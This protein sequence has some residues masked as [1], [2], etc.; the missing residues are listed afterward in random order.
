VRT[1]FALEPGL[2]TQA[3]E[4]SHDGRWPDLS[5]AGSARLRAFYT[6]A[7]TAATAIEESSLLE[8][9]RVDRKIL[10][11]QIDYAL[12]TLDELRPLERNPLTYVGLIGDALDPLLT[13]DFAPIEVRMAS[14][15]SRLEG[16]PAVVAAAR[17]RLTR[18]PRVFTETA[19]A[20]TRGLIEL[21]SHGLDDSLAKVPDQRPALA[22]ASAKATAAL[23]ELLGFFERELLPRSDGDFRLG[24]T[25]FERKLRYELGDSLDIDALATGA[26]AL[27]DSTR[28]D[29]VA[30]SIELWPSLMGKRPLPKLDSAAGK[31]AMVKSVLDAVAADRPSNATILAEATKMLAEA[32]AFVQKHDLVRVPDEPCAVIE[33]PEYRRGV[34]VAY[35][36][37]SGPFE[38]RP[39]TY[40]AISPT[41]KDWSR[42]RVDSF[43]KEYNRSMLMELTIH[44]AMP[45]HFLQAMHNNRFPSKLRALYS[46]GAFVEGWAVY[47]EWVMARY[48]M[49]GPKV[50]LQRQKMVLR[51]CANAILDH[52]IHAGTMDEKQALAL[53]QGDAFQEEGEAVGKWKR[54]RLS[55]AQ[56]STYY[57]GF[58]EFMK[59]RAATETRAGFTERGFHDR[60]LSYGAPPMK[61][62]SELMRR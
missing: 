26:R 28:E 31:R 18:P 52:E 2:A 35:C 3:G 45:G 27:L 10:L 1:L 13:R 61:L 34:A 21:T 4:H 50:R 6:E 46:S 25:L 8:T 12:F 19:I 16:I 39:E 37:S 43:Y 59:I 9:H 20:Q 57:Y 32:T 54:A 47:G 58:S 44:E 40:Y 14:L 7:R 42:E 55:S 51:L 17:A 62:I 30:T 15:T 33:M 48:G 36:E 24:R 41:P 60:L 11:N 38:R 23:T 5:V 22:A 49:G 56:L 53:M 29:M